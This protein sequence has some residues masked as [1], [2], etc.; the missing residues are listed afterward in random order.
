[1]DGQ[2]VDEM[3]RTAYE[4]GVNYFDT[5]PYYCNHHS[6]AALG[7]GLRD[8]RDKVLISTKFPLEL[9][10][11]R[12]TTGGSWK[13]AWKTWA[14]ITSTFTISGALTGRISTRLS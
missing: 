10:K 1:M 11:S 5:A 6:E 4:R 9:A 3:L 2:Q 8:F 14:R 13:R 12:G 7:H